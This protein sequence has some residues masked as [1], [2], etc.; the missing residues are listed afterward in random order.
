MATILVAVFCEGGFE[1][2]ERRTSEADAR[3]FCD[4][5]SVGASMYGTGDFGAYLLPEQ[6]D[7][8]R[9]GERPVEVEK[10]LWAAADIRARIGE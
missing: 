2:I 6:E 5:V 4:G 7:D 1:S 8:M 10:A 9:E 3:G